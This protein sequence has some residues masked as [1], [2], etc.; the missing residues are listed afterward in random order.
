M[1]AFGLR[2][3]EHLFFLKLPHAH[4]ALLLLLF[5][6]LLLELFK[7]LDAEDMLALTLDELSFLIVTERTFVTIVNPRLLPLEHLILLALH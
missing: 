4:G 6:L 3:D 1:V 7:A 2:G 5:L